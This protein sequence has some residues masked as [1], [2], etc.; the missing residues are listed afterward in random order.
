MTRKF[1]ENNSYV[2]VLLCICRA[3]Q[4]ANYAQSEIAT[5]SQKRAYI[6][7][8]EMSK[9][10]LNTSDLWEEAMHQIQTKNNVILDDASILHSYDLADEESY[11]DDYNV[12]LKPENNEEELVNLQSEDNENEIDEFDDEEINNND[13]IENDDL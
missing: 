12:S 11:L 5:T 13:A 10:L 8:N 9:N 4:L 3:K 1:D 2:Q 6:A 7:Y